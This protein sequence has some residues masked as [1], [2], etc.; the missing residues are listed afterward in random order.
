MTCNLTVI[1]RLGLGI[2]EFAWYST[3]SPTKTRGWQGQAH[4]CPV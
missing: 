1:P 3:L 2:H 4:G